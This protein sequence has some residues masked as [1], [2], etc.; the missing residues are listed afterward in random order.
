MELESSRLLSLSWC[1]NCKR[2][3]SRVAFKTDDHCK[4]F[5]T[6]AKQLTKTKLERVHSVFNL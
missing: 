2:Q 4:S 5:W 1:Q 3:K 6:Q